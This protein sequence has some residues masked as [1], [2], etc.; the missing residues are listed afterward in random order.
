M[1][2]YDPLGRVIHL[3]LHI[4][5]ILARFFKIQQ[6]VDDLINVPKYSKRLNFPQF[7]QKNHYFSWQAT[8]QFAW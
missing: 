1:E 2:F 3:L 8:E 6:Q 7:F 4:I 5:I